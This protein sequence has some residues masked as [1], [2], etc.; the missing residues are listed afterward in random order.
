MKLSTLAL[1]ALISFSVN[2]LAQDKPKTESKPKHI[3][4]VKTKSTKCVKSKEQ[5]VVENNILINE[6]KNQ[7]VCEACGRG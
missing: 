5:P 2:A 6:P 4:T 1:G 7:R 3:K